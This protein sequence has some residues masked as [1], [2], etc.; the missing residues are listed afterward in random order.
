MHCYNHI[1]LQLYIVTDTDEK[2]WKRLIEFVAS[3]VNSF[4]ERE[5]K[6][7]NAALRD[8]RYTHCCFVR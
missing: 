8:F 2:L 7:L 6:M 5:K 3:Y 1:F 4:L